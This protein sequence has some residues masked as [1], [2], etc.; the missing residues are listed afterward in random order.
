MRNGT[1]IPLIIKISTMELYG[2]TFFTASMWEAT[3]MQGIVFINGRGLI[4]NCDPN[5]AFMYGYSKE[6][7]LSENIKIIMPSPFVDFHD[8]YLERYRNSGK[9]RILGTAGRMVPSVHADG[10]IIDITLKVTREDTGDLSNWETMLFKGIVK[11]FPLD[12]STSIADR[13][14]DERILA[15]F[16][17]TCACK[18]DEALD[19]V[20]MA[21]DLVNLLGYKADLDFSGVSAGVV[22]HS[23]DV[24]FSKGWLRGMIFVLL[25]FCR[26]HLQQP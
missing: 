17:K 18:L 12:L 25:N 8:Q 1:K 4:V 20:S 22:L 2:N 16:D 3:N 23:S 14:V 6:D 26:N 15:G 9:G 7:L 10:S 13:E 24:S 21:P 5:F 19:I 11:R